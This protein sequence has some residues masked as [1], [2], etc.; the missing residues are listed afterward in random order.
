MAPGHFRIDKTRPGLQV[1]SLL[2]FDRQQAR[3]SLARRNGTS[4]HHSLCTAALFHKDHVQ[5]TSRAGLGPRL[6]MQTYLA[7]DAPSA[8]CDVR[9]GATKP[10][11]LMWC[12]TAL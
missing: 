8:S 4:N 9:R 7:A 5:G 11:Y 10:P 1:R 2:R 12:G 3:L 6:R